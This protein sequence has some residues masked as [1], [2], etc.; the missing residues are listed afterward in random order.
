MGT[1]DIYEEVVFELMHE[2]VGIFKVE[3]GAREAPT[4]EENQ[5]FICYFVC[6]WTYLKGV[7]DKIPKYVEV[8]LRRLDFTVKQTRE[9]WRIL[10]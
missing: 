3:K 9:Q 2:L 7:R 8:V 5:T 4:E 6:T 1:E 10:I